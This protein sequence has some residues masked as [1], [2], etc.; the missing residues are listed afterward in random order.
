MK[1]HGFLNRVFDKIRSSRPLQVAA[2][3]WVLGLIVANV[4]I[5]AALA[6]YL[7]I[8]LPLKILLVVGITF[9]YIFFTAVMTFVVAIFRTVLGGF[10]SFGL[11]PF[12]G[13]FSRH[14]N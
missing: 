5:V 12:S 10:N 14:D 11:N 13:W 8:T 3:L 7:T 9:G 6:S 2:V 1:Q 4:L